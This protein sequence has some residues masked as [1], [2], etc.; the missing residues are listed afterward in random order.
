[1]LVSIGVNPYY[2]FQCRPVKRVKHNF[3]LPLYKGIEIVEKAKAQCNG[4]SK[5]FRYIMSHRTGKIEILGIFKGNILQVSPSKK[6]EENRQ[7]LH[8]TTR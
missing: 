7:N 3:Q 5:R 4:H 6:Q 2:V 1:M 8:Q